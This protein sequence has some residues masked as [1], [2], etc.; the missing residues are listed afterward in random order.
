MAP[1][2]TLAQPSHET[3]HTVREWRSNSRNSILSSGLTCPTTGNATKARVRAPGLVIV[4]R[5]HSG[6]K[7]LPFTS[8]ARC[9]GIAA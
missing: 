1:R 2:P 9:E 3:E 5:H 6:P 8:R 4:G 7:V